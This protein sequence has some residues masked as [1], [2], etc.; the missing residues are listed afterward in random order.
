MYKGQVIETDTPIP[1]ALGELPT[2]S[3]VLICKEG[4]QLL[5]MTIMSWP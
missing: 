3:Y 5:N 2:Y 1:D 4:Y